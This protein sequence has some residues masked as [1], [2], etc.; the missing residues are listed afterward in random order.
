[1][2]GMD[3]NTGMRLEGWPHVAQSIG[4]ILTTRVGTRVERRPYGS[5][6]PNL[7]DKPQNDDTIMNLFSE[8][9]IA[10]DR[11]EPRVLLKNIQVLSASADGEFELAIDVFWLEVNEDRR[12]EVSL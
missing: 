4:D 1:M 9:A 8:I 7:I 10:L 11:W 12:V 6:V 2:L 5:D 3:R